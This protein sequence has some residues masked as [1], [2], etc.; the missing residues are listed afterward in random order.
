[1]A[2]KPTHEEWVRRVIELERQVEKLQS[3]AIKYQTLFHS[4]PHGITVSDGYGNIVETNAAAELLLGLKREE[5]EN[6]VI[7]GKEWRIIRPDGSDMP[8]E[9][10]ASVIALKEKRLVSNCVMGIIT[11]GDTVTWLDVTA[12]PLPIEGHGVV[13]TYRDVTGRKR[14]EEALRDSEERYRNLFELSPDAIVI[15]QNEK[16]VLLNTAAKF[17]FGAKSIDDILGKSIYDIRPVEHHEKLRA[18]IRFIYE[19]GSPVPSTDYCFIRLDGRLIDVEATATLINYENHPAILSLYRDVTERRQAEEALRASHDLLDK[20]VQER[21]VELNNRAVQ[22]SRLSSELTLAEQ[23]ERRRIAEMLHDHHQQLLVGARMGLEV[24]A[25]RIEPALK[26]ETVQIIDL[27][28]QAIET[29]RNLTAELSPPVLSH[30]GLSAALKW[31]A[32]WMMEKHGLTVELKVDARLDPNRE[33]IK[34]L[35]FQSVRELLFNAIKHAEVKSARVEM[36]QKGDT[37]C[38][39]ITDQGA[40]FDPEVM[41]AKAQD[42]TSF[43]LLSIRERLTLLGGSLEM[44]SAPGKGSR[45]SLIVPLS[46]RV[47]AGTLRP[48]A[49]ASAEFSPKTDLVR[50]PSDKIR[51]MLVDDHAVMRQGLSTLLGVHHDVEIVAEAADGEEAVALAAESAPDV[52]LMDISMPKMNGFEA[53]RIIHSR[54]PHIRII[55]LSMFAAKD[56]AAAMIKAGAAAYCCKSD[57]MAV[58][59]AAIRGKSE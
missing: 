12:A 23:R 13:V 14:T 5:H 57:D 42:G 7:D 54:L 15:W 35:L 21:T 52:I 40:G 3:A 1:M 28:N 27:I 56:Q 46:V 9:E 33:D 38:I 44:E 2:N 18:R 53:T 51:V 6:R 39:T 37:F 34:L 20:R 59:L 17:M 26:T 22:L 19:T 36:D 41:W 58:L 43:G 4:F 32:R 8:P 50:E 11:S 30:G 47:P 48:D 55:G 29:S 24:L 16:A 25:H 31:L 10:W 45:F 49:T